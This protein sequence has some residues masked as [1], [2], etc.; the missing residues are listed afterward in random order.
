MQSSDFAVGD[1]GPAAIETRGQERFLTRCGL[2]LESVQ[3][4]LDGQEGNE[5][6][7]RT[8]PRHLNMI[9][10]DCSIGAGSFVGSGGALYKGGLGFV[11]IDFLIVGVMISNVGK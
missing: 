11:L 6:E 3:R 9:A 5:L 2:T 8:K 10:I 7:R 4:R 1:A